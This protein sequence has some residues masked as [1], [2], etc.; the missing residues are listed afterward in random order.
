MGFIIKKFSLCASWCLGALVAIN[1]EIILGK[2]DELVIDGFERACAKYPD[3][4]AIVYLGEKFSYTE[5]KNLVDRFRKNARI[6]K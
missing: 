1:E 5:I 4:T 6:R 3:N 2:Y